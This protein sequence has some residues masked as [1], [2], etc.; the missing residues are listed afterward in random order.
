MTSQLSMFFLGSMQTVLDG[1]PLAFRSRRERALLAYLAVEAARYHTRSAIAGLIYPDMPGED[2]LRNV[3]LVLNRLRGELQERDR[4][5][6]FLLISRDGLQWNAESAYRLDVADFLRLMAEV[7][8]E[9]VALTESDVRRLTE[10]V[11]LYR[12]DF[13]YGFEMEDSDLFEAWMQGWRERLH[14]LALNAMR[15]LA[16]YALQHGQYD[17]ARYYAQSQIGLD[18]WQEGAYRQLMTALAQQ[19]QRRLALKQYDSLVRLLEEE[20]GVPPDPQTI[21]L[22][23][24]IQ[25]QP[26]IEPLVAITLTARPALHNLPPRYTPF[27]GRTAEVALLTSALR[28]PHRRLVAVVGE[29]GMGKSRLAVEVAHHLLSQYTDGVWFVS[30]AMADGTTI[31]ETAVVA[32]IANTL[33][34]SFTDTK[35]LKSQLFNYLRVR[36]CLL[37]LDN[38]ENADPAQPLLMEVLAASSNVSLLVTSRHQL[39]LQAVYTLHLEGLPLPATVAEART[40]PSIQLLSERA[41]RTAAG[42]HLPETDL[43]DAM[44]LCAL[45]HGMPLGIELT[46]TWVAKAGVATVHRQ[47]QN[48]MDQLAVTYQDMP[49]R[50]RS[51]RALFTAS[52]QLLS[53]EEQAAL[54]ALTVFQ[55][56]FSHAAAVEI[57]GATADVL[58]GLVR[59]SLLRHATEGHYVFHSEIR[60]FA[61]EYLADGAELRYRHGY[62]YL[63]WAGQL[64]S[65]LYGASTPWAVREVRQAWSNIRQAWVWAAEQGAW[66]ALAVS[67]RGVKRFIDLTEQL[68]EGRWLFRMAGKPLLESAPDLSATPRLLYG[69]LGVQAA[70]FGVLVGED[71]MVPATLAAAWAAAEAYP[72]EA[73]SAEIKIRYCL[74][75]TQIAQ[76]RGEFRVAL[77]WTQKSEP[78]LPQA[79]MPLLVPTVLMRLAQLLIVHQEFGAAQ[80]HLEQALVLTRESGDLESEA[81]V[82]QGMGTRAFFQ[83]DRAGARRYNLASLDLLLLLHDEAHAWAQLGNIATTYLYDFAYETAYDYYQRAGAGVAQV[84]FVEGMA[85]M[86][87]N[88]GRV[89]R[90][91]GLTEESTAE[92]ATALGWYTQT[93]GLWGQSV[94]TGYLA[95]LAAQRG[96]ADQA[97]DLIQAAVATARLLNLPQGYYFVLTLWGHILYQ[98]GELVA[99]ATAYRETVEWC[100]RIRDPQCRL[101]ALAGLAEIAFAQQDITHAVQRVNEILAGIE[102]AQLAYADE[103]IGVYLTCIRILRA[104]GDARAPRL[105]RTAHALLD[106]QTALISDPTFREAFLQRKAH[107]QLTI[108]S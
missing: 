83:Q 65:Q 62:Y 88:R 70:H 17:R 95:W 105:R 24:Q 76:Q 97:Y 107:Q 106:Q 15:R 26:M 2:A 86:A 40:T 36:R 73:M 47:L 18:R 9:D 44:A 37:V 13:L 60:H 55:E 69:L 8:S 98:R 64:E 7:P 4:T 14:Q 38:F 53:P 96:E 27:F 21:A 79:Q 63:H 30:L 108:N 72:A 34:F 23:T 94:S 45:V 50:H 91:L 77:E 80:R 3:R 43:M 52:W 19:G 28:D 82:L 48:N 75:Q 100:D 71:E 66:Q 1:T 25:A 46:A 101:D 16:E 84:G 39:S 104:V 5:D 67:H 81:R 35:D 22:H 99:A 78:F 87:L 6:P 68:R 49:P 58:A 89:C 51:L 61:G 29:G 56:T 74:V 33:A 31:D 93:G 12:G 57:T 42:W 103:P 85:T 54:S 10:A 90:F 102:Q 41:E 59:K 32:T 92:F 11:A 20:V